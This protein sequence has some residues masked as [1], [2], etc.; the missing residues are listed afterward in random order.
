MAGDEP[1]G[2]RACVTPWRLEQNRR[3]HM[4]GIETIRYA[5]QMSDWLAGQLLDDVK[6]A[7][8]TQPTPRGGNHPLWVAGHLAHT[9]G[10]LFQM[11]T[12]EA[13]PLEHWTPL[14][15]GGTQPATDASAYPSYE[16]VL[17]QFRRLRAQNLKRLESM[18]DA[19]LEK[20][21][22][23]FGTVGKACV[24]LALHVMLHLG[25]V[26]DTR[27]VLGRTPLINAAPPEAAM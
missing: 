24:G 1:P 10:S 19:D 18:S 7:P 11:L 16:E 25:Q 9:V 15:A 3:S 27:R 14:F 20:P 17:G 22:P 21:A 23:F 4:T 2:T 13:N 6:D 8:L 12:G 26:A 5:I